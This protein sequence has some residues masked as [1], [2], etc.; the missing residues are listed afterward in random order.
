M[1]FK[2]NTRSK[3]TDKMDVKASI[4]LKMI[5]V[6]IVSLVISSPISQYINLLLKEYVDG[7][8]GVFVNTSITLL[9]A[10]V[11]ISLATRFLIINRIK[12]VLEATKLAANGDLTIIIEENSKD[13]IGQLASSFNLMISNLHKVVTKTNDTSGK[14]ASYSEDFK[15]S[16][17]QSSAS[18]EQI[19]N[20][21]QTIVSGSE[22]QTTKTSE[23]FKSSKLVSDELKNVASS[24]QTISDIANVTN[25]KADTGLKLIDETINKM[26]TIQ[27]SVM[28]SSQKMNTLGEKSKEIS[29]IVSLITNIADQTNLLAL[30]AS[31]EAARAGDAGKGFAVVAEEVRKLAEGSSKAGEEIRKL[32]NEIQLQTTEAVDS[33]NSGTIIVEDGRG[34]VYKSGEAFKDIVNYVH[35]IG[36]KSDSAI[37]AMV[38]VDERTKTTTEGIRE[39]DDI[40]VQASSSVQ[41]VAASVEEQS[42]SNEEITSSAQLLSEMAN[43]LRVEI[44]K[45]KI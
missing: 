29:Q 42:A 22:L 33:I 20:A 32:V 24:I 41:N 27:H 2:N 30:N 23:L 37:K 6:V 4:R 17:E 13:E 28:S 25:D 36:N 15:V 38:M 7:S 45:F 8:F 31:I 16:T 9:V 26:D 12:K 11:I 43:D 44:S 3:F 14:V 34:M 1:D 21:I 10:T 39:I 19:S 18:V 35:N 5:V 40:A